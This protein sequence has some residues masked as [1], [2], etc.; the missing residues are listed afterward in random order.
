MSD[1]ARFGDFLRAAAARLD[2]A[3]GRPRRVTTSAEVHD[4]LRALLR[5]VTVMSRCITATD[6]SA[7]DMAWR[8]ARE[9]GTW[10]RASR[11]PPGPRHGRRVP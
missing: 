9:P 8:H 3:N 4:T 10:T 11:G 5:M 7:R 6:T 1:R 2:A